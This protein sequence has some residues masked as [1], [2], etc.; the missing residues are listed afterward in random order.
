MAMRDEMKHTAIAQAVAVG[1]RAG[2]KYLPS[3]MPFDSEGLLMMEELSRVP[4][5]YPAAAQHHLMSL[6][7][8]PLALNLFDVA[9]HWNVVDWSEQRYSNGGSA[10]LMQALRNAGVRM[11]Y[12]P[13]THLSDDALLSDKEIQGTFVHPSL[14]DVIDVLPYLQQNLPSLFYLGDSAETLETNDLAVVLRALSSR[15]S[16]RDRVILFIDFMKSPSVI[17]KAYHDYTGVTTVLQKNAL[18]RVNREMQANFEQRQFEYWPIYDATS[19]ACRKYL[20]ST[21]EQVVRIKSRNAEIQFKPWETIS[22]GLA[23]KYS[24]DTF[25]EVLQMSGM[26][27]EKQL[28]DQLRNYSIQILRS[29]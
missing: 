23:Q 20:V 28:H 12:F 14:P 5:Y 26:K 10:L 22:V 24:S 17:E 18:M 19:G 8:R 27:A 9:K 7:A 1:L 21:T 15:M 3:W 2:Q 4:E 16:H 11:E 6:Y 29:I 25:A 13:I